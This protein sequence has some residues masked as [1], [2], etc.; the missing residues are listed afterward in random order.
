MKASQLLKK[1]PASQAII[2]MKIAA[3]EFGLNLSKPKN[4]KT[5]YRIIDHK[6]KYN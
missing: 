3:Q 2:I 4:W 5:I 6:A 1:L